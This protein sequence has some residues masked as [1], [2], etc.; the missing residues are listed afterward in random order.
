MTRPR[1]ILAAA[2]PCLL[3]A[4][5]AVPP[6]VR[7]CHTYD[8]AIM[9]EGMGL[10][11]PDGVKEALAHIEMDFTPIEYSRQT[12]TPCVDGFA[13]VY[14]CSNVDLLAALPLSSIGGGSGND[15]WGWTDPVTGIE[16]ALMGRSTGTAFVSL[17]DPTNPLYVA[18]LPSQVATPS[19]WR[20]IKV[21]NDHAYIVADGIPHGMQVFDLGKLRNVVNPPVTFNTTT[22]LAA[23]YDGFD[24]SHNIVINEVTGFAYAVGV[25]SD[26]GCAAGIHMVDIHDPADP[27]FA[28]C[29]SGDGYTHDAQ[30]I[31]YAGPDAR[32]QGRE[33]CF[34]SNEDSLTIVDVTVKISPVLVARQVYAGSAYT[35][36]GWLTPD[37]R[38]FVHDDELDEQF[39][40]HNT[41]TY[42]W[43]LSDL[44]NPVLV[45]SHLSTLPSIDHN[46]YIRDAF[47]Y[48]SNYRAGL[49]ILQIEDAASAALSEVGFFDTYPGSDSASFSGTWSN[50]PYFESGIVIVSDINRGLFVL[51]PNLLG[52]IFADG[53][54]SGDLSAWSEVVP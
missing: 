3:A 42:V 31:L 13:D 36:Q 1:S 20:D 10:H 16:W 19:T 27:T 53:F 8:H 11:V 14:A 4:S 39:F 24:N 34:A 54:E 15:I 41:K 22:D 49:R 51:Q 35:H 7:A 44:E 48:Q 21:Y 32:Y 28:G 6:P 45:G 2:L 30:C 52:T 37:H 33:L 47:S 18:S 9:L 46:Q 5:A 43:D 17:E 12:L 26:A 25:T 38:Y 40:G 50:Y 23:H 29:Y